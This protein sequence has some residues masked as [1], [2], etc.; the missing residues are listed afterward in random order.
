MKRTI[1]FALLLV[2]L[3]SALAAQDTEDQPTVA[4]ERQ[5]ARRVVHV[6]SYRVTAGD[7]YSMVIN[8]GVNPM[9]TNQPIIPAQEFRIIVQRDGTVDLPYI[10]A[11]TVGGRLLSDV[12]TELVR[13]VKERALAEFVTL[14]LMSPAEFDVFVWGQVAAPGFYT[15]DTLARVSDVIEVAGGHGPDGSRRQ[16]EV[17][18]DSGRVTLDLLKHSSL[19]EVDQ[20]PFVAPGDKIYVPGIGEAVQLTGAV[21]MSGRYEILGDETLA[22]VISYAGGLEPTAQLAK[23]RID[24]L[25][26]NNRYTR[27]TLESVDPNE[28]VLEN[29]DLVTIPSSTTT[30]ETITVEGAVFTAPAT[31]GSPRSIPLTPVLLDIPYTPGVTM[32]SLLEDLGGPTPFAEAERSFVIRG[33]TGERLPIPDLPT[34]WAERQYDRDIVLRPGD[35]LVIP[36]KNLRVRVTGYVN[37]PGSFGF[38][39]GY[40][41]R[42]Y[43]ELAGGVDQVDGNPD[44]V[45]FRAADG[46]LTAVT[47]AT[48]VEPGTTI[49]IDR[50]GWAASKQF[51]GNV[52]TVTGWVTGIVGVATAILEFV[53][54]VTP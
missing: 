23:L 15:T 21:R 35:Y 27:L 40:T 26:E 4:S 25:N 2:F 42:D 37:A 3:A 18:R 16:V 17:H 34:V 28:I 14:E 24:R 19:G 31:E 30:A 20:N 38:T 32:L 45:S 7:V 36:L 10:G 43:I 51:F 44:R 53:Q 12:R 6:S 1:G 8:Y 47:Y 9:I 22:D 50:N 54:L 49:Y 52:F 41:V 5:L 11:V 46:E 33:E 48:P 13:R 39:S 29:G